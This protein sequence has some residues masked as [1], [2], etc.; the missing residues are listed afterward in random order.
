MRR[1]LTAGP[2]A[3]G[4]AL[5]W[6]LAALEP[7]DARPGGGGGR[8][9]RVNVGPRFNAPRHVDRPPSRP[10]DMGQ[11]PASPGQLPARPP[12]AGE[13][14]RPTPPIAGTT[15][16]RPPGADQRPHPE[17]PIVIP[18]KPGDRPDRPG[19]RP[20]GEYYPPYYPGYYPLYPG[21]WPPPYDDY[22]PAPP[23]PTLSAGAVV[24][25]LP[26]DCR[27]VVV[28]DTSYKLCGTTWYAPRFSG[29][30]LVYVVVA[31]PT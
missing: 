5:L 26:A 22:Y 25:S 23:P 28:A 15:P 20:P 19:D 6:T 18:P 16:P 3:L 12:A 1:L 21:Y 27:D 9:A 30:Q 7:A 8:G 24:G 17:H 10:P 29:N 2:I 11:R 31:P 13:A 14:P 4:F